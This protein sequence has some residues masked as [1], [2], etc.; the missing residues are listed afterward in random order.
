VSV[1]TIPCTPSG[2][3]TWT[4]RTQLD[5][6]DYIL[7]FY[8]AQRDGHWWMHVQDVNEVPIASGLKLVTNWPLLRGVR[9]VRRPP[10]SLFI[11]DTQGLDED[12]AFD[13]LGTRHILTYTSA[14]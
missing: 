3:A 14:S 9:D 5:G 11:V 1:E 12:P 6:V 2:A 8:W 4:Q 10:G 13:T 7:V